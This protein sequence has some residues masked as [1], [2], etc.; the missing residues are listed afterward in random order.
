M[1]TSCRISLLCEWD[2]DLYFFLNFPYF[3]QTVNEPK[4]TYCKWRRGQAKII[5]IFIS[6]TSIKNCAKDFS[7]IREKN[8]KILAVI[9]RPSKINTSSE[10]YEHH[11]DTM[12]KK[13]N[14]GTH[15]RNKKLKLVQQKVIRNRNKSGFIQDEKVLFKYKSS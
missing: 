13:S 2:R 12:L 1:Y 5:F 3:V 6:I 4:S 14:R 7:K 8:G 15:L 10:H 11:N 9:D